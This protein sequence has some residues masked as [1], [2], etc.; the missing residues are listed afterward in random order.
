MDILNRLWTVWKKELSGR[1]VSLSVLYS[2]LCLYLF[3]LS[4]CVSLTPQI[5]KS[6]LSLNQMAKIEADVQ[7]SEP[8]AENQTFNIQN[9]LISNNIRDIS[10]DENAVWIATDSGVTMF[11][12]SNNSWRY[13]T[14]EDGLGS[15]NINAVAVD[16]NFVWFGTDD[17][18]SR[19]DKSNNIWRTFKS[20][21]GLKGSKVFCININQNYVWFGTD[22]GLNR[23]DKN[24]DSWAARTKKDGLTED[25][26]SAI[27]I[28]EDYM[29]VGTERSGVN[30]YDRTT[31]SWNTYSKKDGLIDSAITAIAATDKF[32]WFGT[33]KSG[34]SLY[35]RTNQT[36]VK[37]Y[38][39]TD[40][41]SS[42]DIR[43]TKVDGSH[44]W[45]GTANGGV[46]RYIDAVDTWVKYTQNDGLSSNN[47][48]SITVYNNEVW[49]G[50][51]DCGVTMYD[52][53]TNKWKQFAK[54]DTIPSDDINSVVLDSKGD[55]W[56]A[57][58]KGVARYSTS[59]DQWS[60]YGKDTGLTTDFT[61]TV[62]SDDSRVW[63]G[64][65][66]GLA[67]YDLGTEQW[68]YFTKANGL[69]HEFIT[70]LKI[71]NDKA[72]IGTN[73][74]LCYLDLN[75]NSLGVIN[76]LKDNFII[77][78]ANNNNYLWIGTSN[79]LWKCSLNG[80]NLCHYTTEQGL[81]DDYVNTILEWNQENV[82]VGT[83]SGIFVYDPSTD[84]FQNV[85]GNSIVSPKN[86][87]LVL[88]YDAKKQKIWVGKSNGLACY[89]IQTQQWQESNT[90]DK[91]TLCRRSIRSIA[92]DENKLWLGT[93]SGLVEYS[94]DNGWHEH[95]A[96]MTREPFR[97]TSI[98]N[99][100]FDGDYVWFSNWSNS[101][102][103]AIIRFDRCTNTWQ[104]F[105][106][107]TILKDMKAESMTMVGS[108][109]VDK[110]AVWFLTDYGL[111]RYDKIKDIWDHYT[112]KDGLSDNSV[113][114]LSC[115]ENVVWVSYWSTSHLTGADVSVFD[116]K[117]RKWK[118]IPV[119][120]L[121]YPRESV[122]ALCSDG[123]DVWIGIG[124]SG[125]RKIT[126]DGEQTTYTRE[127]GLA[128]NGVS[129]IT[130]DGDE[131]W[132]AH[133]YGWT[134]GSLTRYNKVKNTWQKYSEADVLAASG[135]DRITATQRYIWIIYN[136][137]IQAIT[138]YDKKMDEWNTIK[139]S[140]SHGENWGSGVE[141]I[142]EDGD[143]L[144][145]GTNGNWVKRFHLAS[146]TWTTFNSS[147]GLLASD[148]NDYGL[149]VDERYVWIGTDFGLSRYDKVT[150]SMTNFTKQGTLANNK[151][152]A[153]AVDEKYVWCGTQGGLSRYDKN[154]GMWETYRHGGGNFNVDTSNF[155]E[156]DWSR[157]T[158]ER[159][160]S[161][162]DDAITALSVDSRYLWVGSRMGANRYDKVTDKWDRFGKDNG[163]P[164]TEISSIVV[165]GY[166]VWMGTSVGL[167]KFPRMSDNLNA[168]VTFTSGMEIRQTALTK[169]YATTLVS[170]E[171][172]CV[173]ADQ[174]YIWI[175]TMRGIS[176]YD[177]KKDV[178][179]TFTIEDGLP[180]NE[181]GSVKVDGDIVWFGSGAGVI[182]FDK[183]SQDWMTFS[184]N[185]G[186]SSDKITCIAKD[187]KYIWFGTYDAGVIRYDK[188]KKIWESFSKKDGLSHNCV[189]SMA[190]DD[191]YLWIG[192]QHGL[193]RYDKSKNT[194]T[195]F[196]QYSDSEDV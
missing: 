137:G 40:L 91:D 181:I 94:P 105:G 148:I 106:R 149:K 192:T 132:F 152:T 37:N 17:G 154:Q 29:W 117:T 139:P 103:G 67:A 90:S 111:L 25:R 61:T 55:L 100:E 128:Q 35:D 122:E 165:D 68:Q 186:L 97:G 73:T 87:V 146:G 136:N 138:A 193:S 174:D 9:T 84:T 81:T 168:W 57:T 13:Y 34:I 39:K 5:D 89:D 147:S 151:V 69:S 166:D 156:S 88:T 109:V 32:I 159:S 98:A 47:I 49:F 179:L 184:I 1:A 99:I 10:A 77:S 175:G 169:E 123:D 26:V 80:Q 116:K 115:G 19:Y 70:S 31:D 134:S 14:K 113:R 176:R 121:T 83:R 63:L 120:N 45:I 96:L 33:N 72:W 142:A 85:N 177:K 24:L 130:V 79:G 60:R 71:S 76:E 124:Q 162:V 133:R 44:I 22:G 53:V 51:Y 188:E 163:L 54:S 189:T 74:G 182:T 75:N 48:T 180:T 171:V 119:A 58:A 158:E 150:E 141:D 107:E 3:M 164:S 114:Y 2:I 46:Q 155:S 11:D 129:W 196:T 12:R 104:T 157:L 86:N 144:W 16:G 172:W 27:N 95:R 8:K 194:W 153:I 170:N 93:S 140:G 178:W 36:F 4:S 64:T 42:N 118:T 15:D 28:T 50:T 108:I 66:R 38:T 23:Y 183:R 52:K 21:D 56:I 62:A 125:V 20:K 145:V 191:D 30:R 41:L 173:D 110:D 101:R 78:L 126:I 143:Y 187:G 127:N 6:E 18:V 190:V 7:K 167:C 131:I 59:K 135:V 65:A 112:T 161:L 195:I 185:N 92:L 102:N 82:W 160:N 43:A